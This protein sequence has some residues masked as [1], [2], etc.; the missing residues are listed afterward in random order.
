MHYFILV[1]CIWASLSTILATP[2]ICLPC[3]II[4]HHNN[5]ALKYFLFH[6][7]I[8]WFIQNIFGL[9][10]LFWLI[11]IFFQS[12]LLRGVHVA[13]AVPQVAPPVP[14]T[15][16]VPLPEVVVDL[17]HITHHLVMCQLVT[18]SR[19]TLIIPGGTGGR[20]CYPLL[21]A[22]SLTSECTRPP[23]S[24][25]P[26]TTIIIITLSIELSPCRSRGSGH[27]DGTRTLRFHNYESINCKIM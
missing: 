17:A 23:A 25:G 11:K 4:H 10:I 21:E 18:L 7:N 24:P 6:S 1:I 8:F 3:N 16:G 15:I 12:H 14:A 2:A 19:V 26:G 5:H 20:C 13:L 27:G 9:K 22:G